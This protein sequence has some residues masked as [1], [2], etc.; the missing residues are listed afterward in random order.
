MMQSP[1]LTFEFFP[2]RTDVQQR[3]FWRTLG[4]LETM[5]PA[6]VSV[7]Y[8]ALGSASD[9]SIDLVAALRKETAIPV[10]AHLTCAGRTLSAMNAVLDHLESLGV[11]RIVAL[12]G[13]AMADV[14]NNPDEPVLHYASE[15]VELIAERANFDISVAAY[16]EVHPRATDAESD[17]QW[18]KAKLDAGASRALTQFFFG[19]E[20]FLRW[21]DKASKAGIDKPLIPGILPVHD[22]DKVLNFS[23]RCGTSVPS[24]LV[25]RFRKASNAD[26]HRQLALEECVSLCRHLQREGV[27]DFHFYTLNQSGLAHAVSQELT[28]ETANIAAA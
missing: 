26:S 16:P 28:G 9:A 18:L 23:G 27:N 22:I 24:A 2:P 25:E 3:R 1:T 20:V 13:D 12:G 21:R 6:W 4:C 19:P 8:G 7:T 14:E 10:A 11:K 15:L 5:S 17:M